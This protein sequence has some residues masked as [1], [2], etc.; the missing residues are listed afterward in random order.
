MKFSQLFIQTLREPPSEARLASH[1]L[2]LRAGLIRPGLAESFVYLP[3][4][5]TAQRRIEGLFTQRLRAL[6]AQELRLP[7]VQPGAMWHTDSSVGPAPRA[8]RLRWSGQQELV[9]SPDH[10]PVIAGVADGVVQSY[11]QLPLLFHH[12][13]NGFFDCESRAPGVFGAREGRILDAYVLAATAEDCSAQ[14]EELLAASSGCLDELEITCL[15]SRAEYGTRFVLPLPNGGE[16]VVRCSACGLV[17]DQN[18]ATAGTESP[19]PEPSG[20]LEEI[21]TPECRTIAELSSFLGIPAE[22]TA[23]AVFVVA[24]YDNE[25]DRFI[26]ALLRGDTDLSEAKLCRALGASQI[27]PATEAEIRL[28][29]AEPGFGSPVGISD[30]TIVADSL[31]VSSPNLVAGANRPGYHLL[32]V[33]SGRDFQPTVIADI[34]QIRDGDRCPVCGSPLSLAD[35][36]ELASITDIKTGY[37]GVADARYLDSEGMSRSIHFGHLRVWLDRVLASV[38]ECHHDDHGIVWPYCVAPFT[39]Y[40]MTVGKSSAEIISAADDLH[41]EMERHGISVLFDD[42]D[43]RAGVKFN[44]ADLLGMPVRIAVGERGLSK[45]VVEVKLRQQS[46]VTEVARSAVVK[47]LGTWAQN[48]G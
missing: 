35:V 30:A 37:S 19:A 29:G 9:L 3:A 6:G 41:Q 47:L 12:T 21:S 17:G 4:G 5:V 14:L 46:A 15:R 20:P 32:N 22:R 24:H 33:N 11:R 16:Q 36:V 38:V 39:V 8:T 45:G 7:V 25:P 2:L 42:R 23:K 18:C 44:D 13:W 28:A 31:L 27:S 40:L 10:A 34:R 43:E 1:Q 26:F 48:D